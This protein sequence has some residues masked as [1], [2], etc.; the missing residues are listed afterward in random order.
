MSTTSPA[1]EEERRLRLL[2]FREAVD[3]AS[4]AS[5]A[6][7]RYETALWERTE[8]ADVEKSLN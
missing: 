1:A 7:H 5:A 4:S 8:L 3:A 6:G 2:K